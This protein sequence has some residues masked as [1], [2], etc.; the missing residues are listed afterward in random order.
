MSLSNLGGK[1]RKAEMAA[2]LEVNYS[3]IQ[4]T[5]KVLDGFSRNLSELLFPVQ[6]HIDQILKKFCACA[7]V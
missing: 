6:E 5:Q 4:I 3:I 2:I 1:S 7:R